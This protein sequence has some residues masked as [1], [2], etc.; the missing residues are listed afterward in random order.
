MSGTAAVPAYTLTARILHWVMAS[1]VLFTLPLG[2]VIANN[3]GGPLQDQLY[4]LHRSIGALLLL[5]VQ[6]R[7]SFAFCVSWG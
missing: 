3:W 5:G 6:G 2:L 4:D 1:L 7:A